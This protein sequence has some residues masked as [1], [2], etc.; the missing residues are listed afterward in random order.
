MSRFWV[1]DVLNIDAAI[2][3]TCKSE[4]KNMSE[5][6]NKLETEKQTGS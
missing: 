6:V 3:L 5:K 1:K 4:E 2:F